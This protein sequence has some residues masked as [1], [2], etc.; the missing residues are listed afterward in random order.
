[1]LLKRK[2]VICQESSRMFVKKLCGEPSLVCYQLGIAVSLSIG[3]AGVHP[4]PTSSGHHQQRLCCCDV[5]C[6]H[7]GGSDQS[8]G[9]A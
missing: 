1:M 3:C 2:A 9:Q 8:Y 4:F 5:P 7:E 6:R